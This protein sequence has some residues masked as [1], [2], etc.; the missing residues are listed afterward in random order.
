[1]GLLIFISMENTKLIFIGSDNETEMQLFYNTSNEIFVEI[2]M[3]GHIPAFI[4][5]NRETAIKVSKELK[6]HISYMEV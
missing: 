6:K 2:S 3:D 4:T 5:F 1:M